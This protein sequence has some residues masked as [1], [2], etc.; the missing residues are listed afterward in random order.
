MFTHTHTTFGARYLFLNTCSTVRIG[1]RH[2]GTSAQE[3]ESATPLRPSI[4]K[5]SCWLRLFM[6]RPSPS[7]LFRP[8]PPPSLGTEEAIYP[9]FH[10]DLNVGL[11]V[12]QHSAARGQAKWWGSQ[13]LA[14]KSQ[15]G[16][17]HVSSHLANPSFQANP[18]LLS[19]WCC[20]CTGYDSI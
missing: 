2:V 12:Q 19:L 13:K 1:A 20:T 17:A 15:M 18:I 4:T 16:C 11:P 6:V 7:V 3:E 8:S 5:G 10:G 14:G 9:M